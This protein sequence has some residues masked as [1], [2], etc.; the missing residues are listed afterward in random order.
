MT[1]NERADKA[2]ELK[3]SGTCNCCDDIK[4]AKPAGK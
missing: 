2:A 1:I 3:G 4:A